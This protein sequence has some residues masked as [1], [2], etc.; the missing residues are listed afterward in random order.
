MSTEKKEKNALRKM[1]LRWFGPFFNGTIPRKFGS[2]LYLVYAGNYPL[3]V[4]SSV[5]IK[6]ALMTH[7]FLT[8]KS[9]VPMD[10][11]GREILHHA[12]QHRQ[13]IVIKTA[14]CYLEDELVDP[15]ENIELYREAANGVAYCH[16]LPCNRI[17][18]VRYDYESTEFTCIGK[19][20]PLKERFLA[21]KSL[22][23][24]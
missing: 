12:K 7:L 17:A 10:M 24:E 16:G 8:T 15:K 18:S 2:G 14:V 21:I 11:R 9:V 4:S 23:T 1:K 20:F 6:A 13:P 3:F 19:F 22:T 5:D